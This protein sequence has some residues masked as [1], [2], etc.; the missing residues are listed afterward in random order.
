MNRACTLFAILSLA[1]HVVRPHDVEGPYASDLPGQATAEIVEFAQ[2]PS[3]LYE[4]V[5]LDGDATRVRIRSHGGRVR[6]RDVLQAL[7]AAEQLD[8]AA[9]APYLPEGEVRLDAS[10]TFA[11]MVALNLA[12]DGAVRF[13]VQRGEDDR[14][15][16]VQLD[17]DREALRNKLNRLK[18]RVREEVMDW[19]GREQAFELKLEDGW[20]RSSDVPAAILVHGYTSS[21]AHLA[22]L[23]DKLRE[24]GVVTGTFG[25]PNDGPIAVSGKQLADALADLHRRAPKRKVQ[26][27]AHS[28]GGLV[29]RVALELHDRELTKSVA[30][31][32]TIGTPHRGTAL[33]RFPVSI[34]AWEAIV[35]KRDNQWTDYI[36]DGLNESRLD[37]RPESELIQQLE[38][39]SRAQP[40]VRYS[41]IIG[42]QGL[43]QAAEAERIRGMI[44]RRREHPALRAIRPKLAGYLADLD[45]IIDGKGDG[46]VSVQRGK[47]AGV[48]D[49]VVLA[50]PHNAIASRL[51]E[52]EELLQAVIARVTARN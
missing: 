19:Q 12:F 15:V 44:L 35:D 22:P 40:R 46:I 52:H 39:A 24:A 34:D 6:W 8:E 5:P 27:V 26:L 11:T 10:Y 4:I 20:E 30:R 7:A 33:A 3:K 42:S 45:E 37:L 16:G 29:S 13:S 14:P 21:P 47:L 31:L 18:A 9:L 2:A 48:E 1:V 36:L 49:T 28:M 23:R 25:Y 17:I 51:E 41:V 32:I 50:F 43:I 38:S